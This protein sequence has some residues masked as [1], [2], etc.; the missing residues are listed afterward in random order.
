MVNHELSLT[1]II[2]GAIFV[3]IFVLAF[4][5]ANSSVSQPSS[6]VVPPTETS[7]KTKAPT[8]SVAQQ[9][10]HIVK[11]FIDNEGNVHVTHTLKES[12]NIRQIQVING[13]L[14]N[15]LVTGEDG[16]S[17]RYVT[18]GKPLDITIFSM[19]KRVLIEYDLDD[20]LFL[21]NGRWT[22]DFFHS[23]DIKFFFP[24]NVHLA[25]VNS[26]PALIE[27]NGMYCHA[28]D[29]VLEYVIDEPVI[30][31][32]IV[33]GNQKFTIEI[34]TLAEIPYFIFDQ[35]KKRIF[36]VVVSNNDPV[37]LIIPLDL[38]EN[39]YDV[40]LNEKKILKH[41]LVLDGTH[42]RLNFRADTS[43]AVDIIGSKVVGEGPIMKTP[44]KI[45]TISENW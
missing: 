30:L 31:K 29:M 22:W 34:I 12:G 3:A 27:N 40:Y 35:P 6:F 23:G 21:K 1:A 20:V 39:P 17:I 24:D 44:E 41:E 38:L 16:S 37:T 36:F 42:A 7:E 8:T 43:G 13:T 45:I 11:V 26:S 15:L 32:E 33:W 9:E 14:S 19:E 25:F 10:N 18:S 28:C 5:Y 4:P 2:S